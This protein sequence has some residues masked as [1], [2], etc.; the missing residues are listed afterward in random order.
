MSVFLK[1]FSVIGVLLLALFTLTACRHQSQST[2]TR[3]KPIHVVASLDFYGEVARA[4]LGDHGTVTTIIKSAS[5]D[6]HDFEPTPQDA[7]AVSHATIALANGLGY[8][9]WMQKLIKS[10]GNDHLKGIQVGEDVMAKKMGANEH[11]WYDPETMTR[12]ATYL[13]TQFGKTAPKYRSIYQKNANRYIQQLA[14]LQ[15]Q[16]KKLKQGSDHRAVDVSEPVFDYAL[17]ALGYRRLNQQFEIAV[18]NGTDPTPKTIRNMQ[19]DIK[20]RKI[21]FFVNNSQ[22]SDKTV[23]SLVKLANTH[24]VPVLNVTETLPQGKTYR[25]W[26][27]SQYT[28]LERIQ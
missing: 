24:H 19:N 10:S 9:A 17:N 14:P 20:Q 1:K 27:T 26:M 21:A 25:S 11:I 2:T 18:E 22:T 3:T 13:A 7:A 8:D 16:I 6:P 15:R 23:K 5:V 4:V 12:L 28:Q